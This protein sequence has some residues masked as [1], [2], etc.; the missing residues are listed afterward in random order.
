MM[1]KKIEDCGLA[2]PQSSATGDVNAYAF[3]IHNITQIEEELQEKFQPKKEQNMQLVSD[4]MV[5][6]FEDEKYIKRIERVSQCGNFL[7][8]GIAVDGS[9]RL[10]QANFCKDVMC[11]QC[12]WRRSLRMFGEVSACMNMLQSDYDFIFATF[13]I[14]NCDASNLDNTCDSIQKAYSKMMRLKKIKN[15]VLGA[16]SALEITYN[17]KTNEYHP[18]LHCIFVVP[19]SYFNSRHS[20]ISQKT[21]SLLWSDALGVD[22]IPVIDIRRI[23]GNI[24]SATAEVAKYSV[25]GSQYLGS[26]MVLKALAESLANRKKCSFRGVFRDV[27]R[28][29]GLN[30]NISDD[31]IHVDPLDIRDDVF[32]SFVT[33]SWNGS[34]YERFLY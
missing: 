34:R 30:D 11:P 20:W 9:R 6:A 25:K 16:F 23:K 1:T 21:W 24:K 8:F 7:K 12:N 15:V 29:I 4:Y 22:Y 13:T 3:D 10:V 32:Q 14:K 18:H 28:Q 26:P 27:H 5:L 33:Y 17:R 2:C 31:L 19:K